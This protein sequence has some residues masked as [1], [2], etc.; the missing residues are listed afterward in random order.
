MPGQDE[1]PE[2]PSFKPLAKEER[3][4]GGVPMPELGKSGFPGL[5]KSGAMAGGLKVRGLPGGATL[6][7]RLKRLRKKD[8]AFIAAGL[9]VLMMAPV[10]EHFLISPEEELGVL[11]QGFSTPG[12]G[13]LFP[14]GRSV[15]ESGTGGLS[16]GSLYGSG[17]DVITPLNVRDPSALIMTSGAQKPAAMLPTESAPPAKESGGWKDA[18]AQ[19]A[20][21]GVK[22][23]IQKSPKLPR[24]DVRMSGALRG[25]QAAQGGGGGS[26]SLPALSASKVP[27]RAMDSNALSRAQAAPG[28]RGVAPRSPMSGG[29]PESLKAAGARQSDI[30]NK[31]G[32][33]GNNLDAA[34]REAI[35]GGQG[36]S[37]GAY[38]RGPDDKSPGNNGKEGDKSL[39]ESLALMRAKMEMQKAIDL[40]WKKKEWNEFG[41]KQMVEKMMIESG[42]KLFEK[43]IIEPVGGAFAEFFGGLLSSGAA[44]SGVSCHTGG[45]GS[46]NLTNSAKAKY[47]CNPNTGK[48][49]CVGEGCKGVPD[50]TSCAYFGG[51]SG[52]GADTQKPEDA[53]KPSGKKDPIKQI[54]E[55]ETAAIGKTRGEIDQALARYCSAASAETNGAGYCPALRKLGEALEAATSANS[56]AQAARREL[57]GA[58]DAMDKLENTTL[59]E[60]NKALTAAGQQLGLDA[61]QSLGKEARLTDEGLEKAVSATDRAAYAQAQ[62]HL[63]TNGAESLQTAA[64]ESGLGRVKGD[65]TAVDA[66][67]AAANTAL[68]NAVDAVRVGMGYVSDGGNALKEFDAL[69]EKDINAVAKR[70]MKEEQ[71]EEVKKALGDVETRLKELGG[72]DTGKG[73]LNGKGSALKDTEVKSSIDAIYAQEKALPK[74]TGTAEKGKAMVEITWQDISKA[75]DDAAAKALMAQTQTDFNTAALPFNESLDPMKTE[76]AAAGN[77]LKTAQAKFKETDPRAKLSGAG[78]K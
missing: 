26:Y 65:K 40:K 13:G 11:K 6:V 44:A 74:A 9:A 48:A 45:G 14:D 77:A 23:A 69:V 70:K 3:K 75:A 28:Y 2:I 8:F 36:S 72:D 53:D 39:G 71:R 66:S 4:G 35:P 55:G 18:L 37:E 10:A 61:K 58:Y 73:G 46:T 32:S 30:F 54:E 78:K 59:P 49:S 17:T 76:I 22:K 51:S 16:P 64:G 25:L 29:G 31:G 62:T 19:A 60:T 33:A 52:A 27:N 21:A 47:Y 38:G 12:E 67:A 15:Y 57:I 68:T 20:S 50:C 7:E 41:R 42:F 63:K 5:A 1:H 43:A 34:A 24:P 56:R